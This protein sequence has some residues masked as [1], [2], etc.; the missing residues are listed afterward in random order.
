M[1]YNDP[2]GLCMSH[3][4]GE[5]G[6]DDWGHCGGGDVPTFS[7]TV[8]AYSD[9]A[10]Q[11]YMLFLSQIAW[12]TPPPKSG[13]VFGGGGGPKAPPRNPDCDKPAYAD[14]VTFVRANREAAERAAKATGVPSDFILTLSAREVGWT[15]SVVSSKNN[16]YFNLSLPPGSRSRPV[17]PFR[18]TGG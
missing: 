2:S 10:Y 17:D 1:N 3:L 11:D 15:G 6:G 12:L 5:G 8:W 9:N 18:S 16:N 7:T 13:H 14:A 4:V